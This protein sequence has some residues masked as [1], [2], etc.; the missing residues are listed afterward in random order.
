MKSPVYTVTAAPIVCA[1]A[2]EPIN[3]R[4]TLILFVDPIP[5]EL[6]FKYS[7]SIFNISLAVIELIPEETYMDVEAIPTDEESPI[8]IFFL[9]TALWMILSIEIIT[10]WF[11]SCRLNDCVPDPSEIKLNGDEI[12]VDKPESWKLFT[13]ILRT[14]RFVGNF[15]VPNIIG[16]K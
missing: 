13:S 12:V 2:T 4:V 10:F 5:I 7:L 1:I 16:D 9:W 11:D 3:E 15:F 14:K 6:I 8:V